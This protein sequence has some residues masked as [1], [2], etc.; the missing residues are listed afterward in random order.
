MCGSCRP[1]IEASDWPPLH[2]PACPSI[3]DKARLL[4]RPR[5]RWDFQFQ[6]D[7][8]MGAIKSYIR[9]MIP[10]SILEWRAQYR[11]RKRKGDFKEVLAPKDT[12]KRI[13]DRGYWG[14]SKERGEKYYSG[15]GS[16]GGE[17]VERYI[18][19]VSGF[20][21]SLDHKPDV[22]DLGCGDFAVGTR[23]RPMCG[24]YVAVDVVEGL[25]ERNKL[26]YGKD[27]VDF[28]VVDMINDELPD[29]EVVFIRQV[30]QHLSN[31]DIAQVVP[32]LSAKFRFLILSEHLA[33]S[34]GFV[35]NLDQTR[36]PD[37]RI[38]IGKG[39]SGVVLT[40]QPFNLKVKRTTVLCE[41]LEDISERKG[42][43]RTILYEL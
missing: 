11:E 42:V 31:S 21:Q 40:E 35:P 30:L 14:R 5:I 22:V 41:A 37:I 28:R 39:G 7:R 38:D 18:S 17:I 2:S 36:G 34:D 10:K 1:V 29:G 15:S 8:P 43:I 13:Y 25:I 24:R 26:R 12:F 9:K 23:L 4:G 33:L 16:H 32:K 6:G 19:A 27:R 20:L 3:E